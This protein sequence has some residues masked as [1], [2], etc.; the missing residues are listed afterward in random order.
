MSKQNQ[1][2][3]TFWEKA[4]RKTTNEP[5]VPIGALA[6][7]LFLGAGLNAFHSGE[8]KKAQMLMRGRVFAQGFTVL[9]MCAGAYFGMKPHDRPQN[10]EQKMAK[11]ENKN[12]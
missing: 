9:A 11:A 10:M 8:K 2:D 5:L 4:M 6:T 3:E 7:V 12:I 1:N